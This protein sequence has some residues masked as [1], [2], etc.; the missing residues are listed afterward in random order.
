MTVDGETA[1][2]SS[3]S[4]EDPVGVPAA[5]PPG[6]VGGPL[7]R[8]L[9]SWQARRSASANS[10]VAPS[11]RRR[12]V[13]FRLARVAGV[14]VTVVVIAAIIAATV[15][16]NYYAITPGSGVPVSALIAVPKHLSHSHVG[17]VL[18]TDVELV[19]LDAL[20]YLYYKLDSNDQVV[21]SSE[22]IGNAS[23]AQYDEEGVID[24]YNARQAAT[25]VAL[26]QLGYATKAAANG[27][28]VYQPEPGA[29]GVSG[30]KV[31][32]VITSVDSHRV[33]LIAGLINAL[34]DY[35]PGTRVNVGLRQLFTGKRSTDRLRLG[36]VRIV[37][38]GSNATETCAVYGTETN[39]LPLTLHGAPAACLGVAPEQSYVVVDKP[40]SV[41]IADDGI[42][43]PSAGL[44]FTLGLIEKLDPE[45]LTA[46]LK[47]AATG[48]MAVNGVVGPVGGVAQKTIAVREAGAS[49]FFV[50]P[51]EYGT[52]LANAGPT[53]KVLQV[54][55]ITQA[56][57]D[58]E[59]LGGRLTLTAPHR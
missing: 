17:G 50:P 38:T 11:V 6:P 13:A 40:F 46:G 34:G 36:E 27:V 20:S 33:R 58:L 29:G 25:V 43:G 51:A 9:R 23:S 15:R 59:Q 54:S 26:H 18:L 45:D 31:G 52:A 4:V 10:L 3:P 41:T 49:V 7:T 16:V 42:S 35:A 19:P 37:G 53:L 57:T 5:D 56:I 1:A 47:I 44:A 55:S 21:P 30:L 22:L 24:M 28:I 32:D 8:L 12:R 48:T 14:T 39:L 2:G